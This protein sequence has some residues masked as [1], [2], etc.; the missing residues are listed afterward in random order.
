MR[1]AAGGPGVATIPIDVAQGASNFS[2]PMLGS[3]ARILPPPAGFSVNPNPANLANLP[4]VWGYRRDT[5][6][7]SAPGLFGTDASNASW[8]QAVEIKHPAAGLQSD[9]VCG[10]HFV[11]VGRSFEV[12][13]AGSNVHATLLADGVYT[14]PRFISTQLV[15]GVAGAPLS[16]SNTYVRF[17]FGAPQER[18]ISLYARSTQGI[19]A[20]AVG[21]TEM[22]LP[23]DR[24][25]EPSMCAMTDSYGGALATR[26][27][28]SGP[29]WEAAAQLGIPHVDLNSIGG[30]GYA[31]VGVDALRLDPANAFGGR[32]A[33][34]VG[35][36]PDLFITAG[37]INDN[38]GAALPPYASAE[39]ARVGFETAVFDF[40]RVLRAAL[41]N[42]VLAA[43]GP[44]TPNEFAQADAN[45]A[46]ADTVKG[47]LHAVAGPWVFLDNVRGGWSNSNGVSGASAGRGWQTGSGHEGVPTGDGNADLYISADGT[48]PNEAGVQYLAGVLADN[49]RASILAF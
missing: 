25:G 17:D 41:P 11:H 16:Q 34:C 49:L 9:A 4:E 28:V 40:F 22:I 27:G 39:A 45:R 33:T 12:L 36:A 15:Q 13:F 47:A 26:W 14:T 6:S 1:R 3:T 8:Y 30:T 42:A 24:S 48:H 21:A 44:W 10:F 35:R 46:K 43:T 7:L 5:W 19:C 32:L 23:W 31:P 38:N 20:I 2:A 18:R 29:F 37:G